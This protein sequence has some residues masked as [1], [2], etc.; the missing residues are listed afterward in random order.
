MQRLAPLVPLV[1]ALGCSGPAFDEAAVPASGG[2]P[3]TTSS[4]AGPGG[5]GGSGG[6]AGG[7]GGTTASGGSAGSAIGYLEDYI[8]QSFVAAKV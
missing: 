2:G 8:V 3:V 5:G 7:G 4:D 6:A 1:L